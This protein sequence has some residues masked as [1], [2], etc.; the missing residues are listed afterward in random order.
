MSEFR[1]K[2]EAGQDEKPIDRSRDGEQASRK[3]PLPPQKRP[4]FSG[5]ANVQL[6]PSSPLGRL[7]QTAR[8]WG[9]NQT[10]GE[11]PGSHSDQGKASPE[12]LSIR[13]TPASS[14]ANLEDRPFTNTEKGKGRLD[15]SKLIKFDDAPDS[16]K[17]DLHDYMG[18][19]DKKNKHI[20][21]T[22]NEANKIYNEIVKKYRNIRIMS[23]IHKYPMVKSI[24]DTAKED[25]TEIQT[26]AVHTFEPSEKKFQEAIKRE[27]EIIYDTLDK[28]Y[29]YNRERMSEMKKVIDEDLNGLDT[30]SKDF[31][32]KCK[33]AEETFSG[34][35]STIT[36]EIKTR[37][38]EAKAAEEA[39]H[40]KAI[41]DRA[42]KAAEKEA[43]EAKKKED[44][45]ASKKKE[46]EEA[47][48]DQEKRRR[49]FF[50]T[51]F[52][53]ANPRNKLKASSPQFEQW[54]N[55]NKDKKEWN[56]EFI[57]NQIQKKKRQQ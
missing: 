32:E 26:Y 1:S 24:F 16:L 34:Y 13:W 27:K 8:D 54:Y 41:K 53:K 55:E 44:L 48:K 57:L 56:R 15:L 10:K 35:E 7:Q 28:N 3:R 23:R 11:A 22:I 4:L 51:K 2:H 5:D 19:T 14:I 49:D 17:R 38:A 25:A 47:K 46:A 20:R 45:E 30:L 6:P 39:E 31:L 37:A 36:T 50:F 12:Q 21:N 29:I 33:T 9:E 18:Q 43:E 52:R 40:L 42:S